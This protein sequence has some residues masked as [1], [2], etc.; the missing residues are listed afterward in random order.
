MWGKV[1]CGDWS[2]SDAIA[3]E[4]LEGYRCVS[5]Y[6]RLHW[7]WMKYGEE[8]SENRCGCKQEARCRFVTLKGGRK[9]SG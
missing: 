1:W 7:Y 2:S 8:G 9:M 6:F 5:S 4:K 3:E